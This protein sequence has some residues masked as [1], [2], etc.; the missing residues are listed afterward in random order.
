MYNDY[1][2]KEDAERCAGACNSRD[3]GYGDAYGNNV[4]TH[5]IYTLN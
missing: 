2:V 5:V 1:T 3:Y 4:S